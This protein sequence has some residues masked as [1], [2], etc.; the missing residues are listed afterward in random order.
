[1]AGFI[2]RINS[3]NNFRNNFYVSFRRLFRLCKELQFQIILNMKLLSRTIFNWF[4]SIKSFF[5]QSDQHMLQFRQLTCGWRWFQMDSK[6]R[7]YS[8]ALLLLPTQNSWILETNLFYKK[9]F[10]VINMTQS[11]ESQNLNASALRRVLYTLIGILIR[12]VLST[13]HYDHDFTTHFIRI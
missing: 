1:M 12:C 7:K 2:G 13:I 9:V 3:L 11:Q 10:D 6:F 4:Y 8:M 5:S